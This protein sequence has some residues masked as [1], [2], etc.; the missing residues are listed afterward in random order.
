MRR[1]GASFYAPSRFFILPLFCL[2]QIPALAQTTR[3]LPPPPQAKG[4]DLSISSAAVRDWVNR[5]TAKDPR[6]R[7]AAE[8]ALVEGAPRS[9][10]LLRRLLSRPNEEVHVVTLEI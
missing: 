10:P 1:I 5:L 3:S 4:S 2:L 7:A 9:L 8:A 6:V